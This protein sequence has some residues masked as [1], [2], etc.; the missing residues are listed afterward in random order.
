MIHGA[1]TVTPAVGEQ[2]AATAAVSGADGAAAADEAREA[3][4]RQGEI[5]DLSG[6]V[7]LSAV[8]TAPV[9]FAVMTVEVFAD[10]HVTAEMGTETYDALATH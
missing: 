3:Q 8:L 6:R 2:P 1:L 9:L 7:V 5:G 4:A 10:P